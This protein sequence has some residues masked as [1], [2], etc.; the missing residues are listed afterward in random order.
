MS[1]T[2]SWSRC[3][4]LYIQIHQN[5]QLNLGQYQLSLEH[6]LCICEGLSLISRAY[7]KQHKQLK[8]QP[9]LHACNPRTT[10]RT[11]RHIPMATSQPCLSSWFPG[12]GETVSVYSAYGMKFKAVL[13]PPVT[14]IQSFKH[15]FAHIYMCNVYACTQIH[16]Y[17]FKL[18]NNWEQRE[19][20][21][22]QIINIKVIVPFVCNWVC[23]KV[24]FLLK[25]NMAFY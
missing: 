21:M 2:T 18:I 13:W 5:S 14:Y 23:Y 6:L 10:A 24:L 15:K 22:W 16:T 19:R 25:Q 20:V 4:R 12:S 8:T 7:L 3:W 11:D 17:T 1:K 9:W